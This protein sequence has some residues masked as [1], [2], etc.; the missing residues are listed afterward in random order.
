MAFG[1]EVDDA[2]LA[3]DAFKTYIAKQTALNIPN[4]SGVWY[5]IKPLK[6]NNGNLVQIAFGIST[7]QNVIYVRGM[8]SGKYGEWR[9][10]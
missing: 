6:Y 4:N 10:I 8:A 1:V 5:I 7:N 2:N 3:I 9:N